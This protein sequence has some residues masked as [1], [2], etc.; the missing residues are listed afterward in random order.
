MIVFRNNLNINYY[1]IVR[2]INSRKE[3]IVACY[4]DTGCTTTSFNI[5]ALSKLLNIKKDVLVNEI[6][7]RVGNRYSIVYTSIANGS[8]VQSIPISIKN[9]CIDNV[10]FDKLNC[11]LNLSDIDNNIINADPL[12]LIGLDILR[13]FNR[14]V[15][16]RDKIV[17]DMF[18]KSFY[19]SMWCNSE[20]LWT[21]Y[22]NM[23]IGE[24]NP[25]GLETSLPDII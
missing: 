20:N 9:V 22:M 8:K 4:C 21:V 7:S 5:E 16:D 24:P 23:P 1:S 11:L 25:L 10:E 17:C 2:H 6:K 15:M 3:H 13:S 19:D 14:V 12:V 18:D